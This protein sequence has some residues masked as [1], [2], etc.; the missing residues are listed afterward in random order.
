[1]SNSRIFNQY[2][3]N[4]VEILL[5]F[6]LRNYVRRELKDI[7]AK[8][9]NLARIQEIPTKEYVQSLFWTEF[10]NIAKSS[11][12]KLF[13]LIQTAPNALSTNNRAS[14]SVLFT[15]WVRSFQTN[16]Y[17]D[18]GL[19]LIK[20]LED[21]GGELL[22]LLLNQLTKW[23]Q[24]T[25]LEK[26]VAPEDIIRYFN[27]V[28]VA[29]ERGLRVY[30]RNYSTYINNIKLIVGGWTT[31][32]QN[33]LDKDSYDVLTLSQNEYD[34][35]SL[36]VKG[37]SL[38]ELRY[39][40]DRLETDYLVS[41]RRD[42]GRF[43]KNIDT[44]QLETPEARLLTNEEIEDILYRIQFVEPR[45]SDKFSADLAGQKIKASLWPV[46][47]TTIITPSPL[48][49]DRLVSEISTG[50]LKSKIEGGFPAG[51]ACADGIGA[52]LS[53]MSLDAIHD[54]GDNI[55][56]NVN[57]RVTDL[58]QA[59]KNPKDVITTIMFRQP[60]TNR[61]I[62]LKKGQFV[63]VTFSHLEWS[64]DI[65]SREDFMNQEFAPKRWWYDFY[66]RI[67]GGVSI[68][69]YILRLYLDIDEMYL[70]RLEP[71]KVL[72]AICSPKEIAEGKVKIVKSPLS[73]PIIEED[74]RR[75]WI[76][77]LLFHE[78]S[79]KSIVINQS[80]RMSKLPIGNIMIEFMNKTAI[81]K[82]E[83]VVIQGIPG[84]ND[85][86]PSV[87]DMWKVLKQE[88]NVRVEEYHLYNI[89][90]P[91]AI[92]PNRPIWKL[93][94][95]SIVSNH[96]GIFSRN[97]GNICQ[98]SY[99]NVI[100]YSSN[101]IIFV[102]TLE[103]VPLKRTPTSLISESK[104]F[105]NTL[106]KIIN[107]KSIPLLSPSDEAKFTQYFPD[108]DPKSKQLSINE[109][110]NIRHVQSNLDSTIYKYFALAFIP[111][112][113]KGQGLINI[114][115]NYEVD[116]RRTYSGNIH[117]N[118][119]VLGLL[120][121]K[122]YMFGQ[123]YRIFRSIGSNIGPRHISLLVDAMFRYG[124]I[125]GINY[126]GIKSDPISLASYQ[127]PSE[128]FSNS[129]MS[130]TWSKPGMAASV[131]MNSGVAMGT[132]YSEVR[133]DMKKYRELENHIVKSGMLDHETVRKFYE[134]GEY[135]LQS[136]GLSLPL[137]AD[138]SRIDLPDPSKIA[139]MISG[140]SYN[141]NNSGQIDVRVQETESR[142]LQSFVN[143]ILLGIKKT[144]IE[145]S[146]INIPSIK[147]MNVYDI[148][149]IQPLIRPLLEKAQ[150]TISLEEAFNYQP[151]KLISATKSQIS[152]PIYQSDDKLPVWTELNEEERLAIIEPYVVK[153]PIIGDIIKTD[154]ILS[155]TGIKNIFL[156]F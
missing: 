24:N 64:Y 15:N 146:I 102:Q 76:L 143:E 53:Q 89:D 60:Q 57:V 19:K 65:I 40:T 153:Y 81:S 120:A 38:E 90:Y 39:N 20:V 63:G 96:Y 44:N 99:M 59:S 36:G 55:M 49:I 42:V 48:A 6:R 71:E 141:T 67:F 91:A 137:S 69:S 151:Y 152:G 26:N 126:S 92:I 94:I 66:W 1:M 34:Q 128:S 115:K 156:Q 100:G 45:T 30:A 23:Q 124:Q 47:E 155:S 84:I 103:S 85:L 112:V 70:Y 154:E 41:I 117:E 136:E 123:L 104:S 12:I 75:V 28:S 62:Q 51:M 5:R 3:L 114:L 73:C 50:F 129:A 7:V 80:D 78:E 11:K 25:N 105:I 33:I 2:E 82:L 16:N 134:S 35:L 29:L 121:T 31:N 135:Q 74:G 149:G 68:P 8:Y 32:L 4:R 139:F 77:D 98:H 88:I 147:N 86:L 79:I 101:D 138:S 27:S 140:E 43:V 83:K 125:T 61:S 113:G 144:T 72:N 127:R 106:N 54:A 107:T 95:D 133:S 97:I 10:Q 111:R 14:I 46:L 58:L 142:F 17:N 119:E 118:L 148:M 130:G 13:P 87:F 22:I 52:P 110:N 109:L 132:G 56:G 93:T 18:E 21:Q 116:S 108:I 37:K 9:M 145:P 122:N 131:I 150:T